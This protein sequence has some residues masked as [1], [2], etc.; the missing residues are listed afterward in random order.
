MPGREFVL[1]VHPTI[2]EK[3][4]RLEEL[5]GNLWYSWH[6]PARA[7][8]S[9][10]DRDLWNRVGHN[11]KLFLRR[12]DERILRKAAKNQVY[13]GQYHE[14]LSAYDTYHAQASRAS[15]RTI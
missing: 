1:D 2:P 12:V 14:V 6:R 10:L 9:S 13:L 5:A 8:F 15:P 3:L 11:P 7:L 4:A